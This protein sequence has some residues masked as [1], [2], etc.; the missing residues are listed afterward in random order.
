MCH[1]YTRVKGAPERQRPLAQPSPQRHASAVS[2]A[3]RKRPAR[4]DLNGGS[5]ADLATFRSRALGAGFNLRNT[6]APTRNP[7]ENLA[8]QLQYVGGL[9]SF[10]TG[11]EA[12][13]RRPAYWVNVAA[14]ALP[15]N[16]SDSTVK[17]LR[18]FATP[19]EPFPLYLPDEIRLIEAEALARTGQFAAAA[20]LVNAVRTQTAAPVDEP[21]G[22]RATPNTSE[23][24]GSPRLASRCVAQSRSVGE[25]VEHRD[26][27]NDRGY[28]AVVVRCSDR[29]DE[30]LFVPPLSD[31]SEVEL[32][33]GF[34]LSA[35]EQAAKMASVLRL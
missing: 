28:A 27:A 25:C 7:I 17:P 14:A 4:A 31:E 9:Q 12:G 30:P 10:V 15:A 21:L 3:R 19:N 5:E 8:F 11:A 29:R 32:D 33:C 26:L 1:A 18:K 13:D 35:R 16:P 24:A 23:R 22:V 20:T 6:V 34:Q 2:R